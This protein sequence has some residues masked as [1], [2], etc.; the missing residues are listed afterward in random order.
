MLLIPWGRT[1]SGCIKVPLPEAS[2]TD[3]GKL[4]DLIQ[5]LFTY[6]KRAWIIMGHATFRKG[7]LLLDLR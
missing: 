5:D 1:F 2:D 3:A 6:F 4:P 7:L